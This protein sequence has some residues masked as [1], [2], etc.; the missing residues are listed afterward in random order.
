MNY[1]SN[2]ATIPASVIALFLGEK[3]KRK[4]RK[5]KKIYM[6]NYMYLRKPK[7]SL[8]ND[9]LQLVPPKFKEL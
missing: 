2:C 5:K 9:S 8:C 1:Q 7:I 3:K 6:K 4:K